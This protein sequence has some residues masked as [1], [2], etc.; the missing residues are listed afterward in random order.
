MAV[1]SKSVIYGKTLSPTRRNFMAIS[2]KR[3][4][5]T[6][7]FYL[8]PFLFCFCFTFFEP[9]RPPQNVFSLRGEEGVSSYIF[10]FR[11]TYDC[12]K[13]RLLWLEYPSADAACG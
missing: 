9:P 8:F 3:K 13:S 4:C 10:F 12:V 2:F 11:Q 5:P 1:I 7:F 6:K